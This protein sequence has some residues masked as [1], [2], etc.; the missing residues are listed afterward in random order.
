M[1]GQPRLN[2]LYGD[3]RLSGPEMLVQWVVGFD[4]GV[5]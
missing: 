3:R 5:R 4:V 1:Y 2:E